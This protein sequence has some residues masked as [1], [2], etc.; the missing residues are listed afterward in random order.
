M[1][2]RFDLMLK[3]SANEPLAPAMK[4]ALVFSQRIMNK[5][6]SK[7]DL[8]NM[9]HIAMGI[10]FHLYRCHRTDGF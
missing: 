5:Y 8:S 3:D 4:H 7:T 10:T 6:Y 2:D 1:M 9:Y